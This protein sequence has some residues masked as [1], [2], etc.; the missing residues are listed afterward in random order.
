[1]ARRSRHEPDA[2]GR[3]RSFR[4][5]AAAGRDRDQTSP[6]PHPSR[7]SIILR[8]ADSPAASG[9]SST[10]K[11]YLPARYYRTDRVRTQR[12]PF[13]KRERFY[14]RSTRQ[15]TIPT[16]PSCWCLTHVYRIHRCCFML[17]LI[18]RDVKKG[19]IHHQHLQQTVNSRPSRVV[20]TCVM[21]M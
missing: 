2:P 3:L 8:S 14:K 9:T 18:H 5:T 10:F 11:H 15:F 1:M 4:R 16:D 21:F 17:T 12:D 20:Q 6:I 7:H 13:V 19:F